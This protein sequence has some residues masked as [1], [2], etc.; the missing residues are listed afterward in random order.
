MTLTGRLPESD[1]ARVGAYLTELLA[2]AL[3]TPVAL[4]LALFAQPV[5]DTPFRLV[6][7]FQLGAL[8]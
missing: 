7:R 4:G 2:P 3:A 5:R 1:R 6:R 8:A